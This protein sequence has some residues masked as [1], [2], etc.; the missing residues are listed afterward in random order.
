MVLYHFR[1]VERYD[2]VTKIQHLRE[3]ENGN[4]NAS[5]FKNKFTVKNLHWERESN[6]IDVIEH[7]LSNAAR[8]DNTLD[9]QFVSIFFT[10]KLHFHPT[11]KQ[12][13]HI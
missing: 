3:E 10:I 2:F 9:N 12:Q 4:K 5:R 6:S 11:K 8:M 1:C 7:Q 13:I